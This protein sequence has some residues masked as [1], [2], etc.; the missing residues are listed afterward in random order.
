MTLLATRLVIRAS[1]V[2]MSVAESGS[3]KQPLS[4]VRR[5]NL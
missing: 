1:T 2:S 4:D 5:H 3:A